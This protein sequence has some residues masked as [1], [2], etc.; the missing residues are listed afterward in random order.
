M[1]SPAKVAR[2]PHQMGVVQVVIT[3]SQLTPPGSKSSGGLGQN[4][5]GVQNNAVDT[6]IGSGQIRLT[7]L[8]EFIG[9]LHWSF[10]PDMKN[11][12]GEVINEVNGAETMGQ[13][14]ET[15]YPR[16]GKERRDFSPAPPG[17]GWAARRAKSRSSCSTLWITQQH[18]DGTIFKSIRGWSLFDDRSSPTNLSIRTAPKGPPLPGEVL[19]EA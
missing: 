16:R 12:I 10:L 5:V 17:C 9:H 19:E 13:T 15:S 7:G 1:D 18:C 11:R 8:R 4:E 6:I 14:H 2:E 3:A